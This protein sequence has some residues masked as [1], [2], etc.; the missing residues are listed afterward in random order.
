MRSADGQKDPTMRLLRELQTEEG[1]AREGLFVA[2]GEELTR[3]AFD[4]G[5]EVVGLVIS[6]RL[7]PTPRGIALAEEAEAAGAPVCAASAGLIGKMLGA[8][9]P[10]DCAAVVRRKLASLAEVLGAECPLVIMVEHGE[11]ADN[12]GMLLRSADAAGV[13][14]AVLTAGTTDPFARKVVRASRG[15]VFSVPVCI[16]PDASEAI[17]FA[18]GMLRDRRVPKHSGCGGRG[19]E[20]VNVVA[21][22][23]RAETAYTDADLTGPVMLVVGNEHTGISDAVRD[24]SDAVVRIPMR[25]RV[26]S[27]NIAAAAT[28]LLYEAL[29]QRGIG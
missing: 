20:A 17:A 23:A 22:S 26:N 1:R 2:E 10:P 9:P 7:A 3:R 24:A 4:Y 25:G 13:D 29:R 18:R 8:K 19:S 11:N 16:R 6:D 21:A 12:L 5:A 27:L 15:A 28:V 14:G